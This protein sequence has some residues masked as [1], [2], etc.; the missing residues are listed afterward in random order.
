MRRLHNI[1]VFLLLLCIAPA[2]SA[3]E[4][5]GEPVNVKE[6]VFGHIG[7]S[8]EWHITTW[9]ETEVRIPLPVIVYSS[10]TGWH[11][12]LSSELVENGGTYQGLSIAPA[13]SKYEGKI[14]EHDAAGQ[15][16]RPF[17]ISIT[18][19]T[20]RCLLTACCLWLLCWE[21]LAGTKRNP[22]EQPHP[23]GL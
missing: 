5:E 14:V 18:K 12:F 6:I 22:E 11:A 15:E 13:G 2:V 21:W 9:G 17:D 23:E 1:V 8:Y 7:D 4:H 19:V 20:L 16:V 10:T 3:N